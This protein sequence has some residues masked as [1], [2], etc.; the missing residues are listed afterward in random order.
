[1]IVD[2]QYIAYEIDE[3]T[4]EA[5]R[6]LGR[7][8]TL[9]IVM[10]EP[11]FA[12]RRFV[13]LK[14]MRAQQLGVELVLSE[15]PEGSGTADAARAVA[16]VA[17]EGDG[18]VIQ[19]P[20]P[21]HIDIETVLAALP[22]TH[23]VDAIG[24]EAAA[25]LVRGDAVVMPPVVG[26]IAEILKRHPH[27]IAEKRALVVGRGRLVG[28][29]AVRWFMQQG[30]H[31]E[32]VDKDT[33]NIADAARRADIIVLGAGSPG[34][35]TADMVRDGVL[36]FDAGSSE[37]QGRLVGDA[38]SDVAAKA[39]LLTPV[40]GGIGPITISMLFANL[41]TLATAHAAAS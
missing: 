23:D 35:L 34:C 17:A 20:F 12:A 3:R 14:R 1:M 33:A 10:C 21:A 22:E 15:L 18:V 11:T 9:H 36:I 39:A 25:R 4:R 16:R 24:A 28:A 26:A 38:A 2:G 31:V 19:L 8:P 37:D 41:L 30:A 27:S 40:P 7:T 32:V 29:P 13:E 5:V 6:A